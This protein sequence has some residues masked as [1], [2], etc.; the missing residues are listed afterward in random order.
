MTLG[1]LSIDGTEYA[2]PVLED[3]CKRVANTLDMFAERDYL[4]NLHRQMIG[5]Y[6]NY[7]VQWARPHTVAAVATYAALY[8]D[9]TQ[10]IEFRTFIMPDGYS[11]VGYVGDGASDTLARIM[12]SSTFWRN[13]SASFIAQ[14]P[15]R[16]P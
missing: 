7:T 2:V 1:Y 3:G 11:F 13:L 16:T 12:D 15:A 4:G 9:L 5:V 14:S 8:S 10:A 6:Y